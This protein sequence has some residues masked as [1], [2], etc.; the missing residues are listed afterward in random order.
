MRLYRY[1]RKDA[2]TEEEATKRNVRSD[3]RSRYP[4][5]AVTTDKKIA[6]E[7]EFERNM[8][9]YFRFSDKIDSDDEDEQEEIKKFLN[10][11]RGAVLECWELNSSKNNH[12]KNQKLFSVHLHV[13]LNEKQEVQESSSFMN[14]PAFWR[15]LP[16]ISVFL[17]KY[18]KA[19]NV[20]EYDN[21]H[22][23]FNSDDYMAYSSLDYTPPNYE[24]DELSVFIKLFG[25]YM[26]PEFLE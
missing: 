19:L 21:Q 11:N 15:R 13:T 6:R 1:Y 9:L 14:D 4:L 24:L 7:F 8:D 10:R 17:K 22:K 2:I 16:D 12:K 20:M 26:N 23:L 18:K 3:I 25:K 5:A